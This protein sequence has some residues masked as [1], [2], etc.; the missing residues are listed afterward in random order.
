VIVSG[1]S[2]DAIKA[3]GNELK[4]NKQGK[5]GGGGYLPKMD[6]GLIVRNQTIRRKKRKE[7]KRKKRKFSM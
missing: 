3:G 4:K 7:K 5:G 6:V 1:Q 2:F